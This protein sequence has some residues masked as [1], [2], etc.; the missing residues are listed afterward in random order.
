MGSAGSLLLNLA[1]TERTPNYEELFANGPHAATAQFEIGD[2]SLGKERSQ[3]AELTWKYDES[4]GYGSLGGF[5]QDYHD[6]VSLAPTGTKDAGTGFD[7]FHY[8]PMEA[9]F[10][11]FELEYHYHLPDWIP[12]GKLEL[13]IKGDTLRA[14]N[15][16]N[17]E[18]LPRITPI[19][20]TLGLAYRAD[21]YSVDAEAQHFE[22]QTLT[23]PDETPTGA[24]TWINLGLEAPIKTGDVKFNMVA[25]VYNI[26]D[27]AAKNH[28]SVIKDVAP[29]PGRNFTLGVQAAF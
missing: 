19:R 25:R 1:Y 10:Y 6:Y 12:A 20:E 22:S 16:Q 9:R 24:Y 8:V 23:A 26:F 3:S 13:E 14:Y 7:I 17:G 2:T 15:R 21:R 27:V 18:N 11:G 28:V 4:F 29:L 5:I